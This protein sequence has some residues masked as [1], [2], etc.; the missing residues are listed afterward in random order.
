M[1]TSNNHLDIFAQIHLDDTFTRLCDEMGKAERIK[2]TIFPQT[3]R[4]VLHFSIYLF[5]TILSIAL[6]NV[7]IYFQLPLLIVISLIFFLMEKSATYLQNPFSNTP[8]DTSVTAIART[9]EINIKQLLG[10]KEIP[11]PSK[12]DTFYIL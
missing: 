6:D 1:T 10:E 2:G 9:I 12:S 3:Y 4:L 11:E 5:V 8:T 7:K